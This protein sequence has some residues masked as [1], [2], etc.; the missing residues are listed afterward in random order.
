MDGST[1]DFIVRS[2]NG[3]RK[4]SLD[5]SRFAIRGALTVVNNCV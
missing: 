1:G 2:V 3:C 4:I 5:Y